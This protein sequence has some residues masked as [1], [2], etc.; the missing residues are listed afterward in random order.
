VERCDADVGFPSNV[1]DRKNGIAGANIIQ[2]TVYRIYTQ[3]CGSGIIPDSDFYPSQIPDP[4]T[5]PKEEGEIF[6][7]LPFFVARDIIKL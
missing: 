6:F 4:T 3:C 7:V 1:M 2:L 5:A